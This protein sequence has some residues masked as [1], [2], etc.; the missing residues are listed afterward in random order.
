V[1]FCCRSCAST[2]PCLYSV[3]RDQRQEPRQE[4]R[5][6]LPPYGSPFKLLENNPII[7]QARW[8]K[9]KFVRNGPKFLISSR[10]SAVKSHSHRLENPRK[11]TL[12]SLSQADWAGQEKRCG[13]QL[14]M[15]PIRLCGCRPDLALYPEIASD[16]AERSCLDGGSQPAG[17]QVFASW[18][19]SHDRTPVY[20]R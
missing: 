9:R 7:P 5:Q 19:F 20:P 4:P 12:C 6:N 17:N 18:L 13:K 15:F 1:C 8:L 14:P 10:Q 11:L 3:H 2:C 16:A